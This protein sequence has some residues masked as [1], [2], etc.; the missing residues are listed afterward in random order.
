MPI[1]AAILPYLDEIS[2]ESRITGACNTIVKVP[3]SSG[4]GYKLVGQN[5]DIL[6]VRNA[7]LR[8]L[9]AQFPSTEIP[10]EVSFASGT[11]AGVIIGGG[12][13]TRSAAHALTLLG[14]S[15]IFLINRDL[16]EVRAVQ[17]SLPHLKLVLLRTPEDVER[18]LRGANAAEVLMAVGAIPSSPPTTPHERMVY[19]TVS[20]VFT[21][22][23]LKPAGYIGQPLPIPDRRIFLEMAYKPRLTPMLQVAIAHGW[24]GVDGI[25][26]MIEQG[27]AQQRMWYKTNHSLETGSDSTIFKEELERSARHLSENM[28]DV[29]E[30]GEEIDRARNVDAAVL[31]AAD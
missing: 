30:V 7:L 27:L 26:A 5:T 18:H 22:P 23:Y 9:R 14:L 13:T 16:T 10:S 12:A 20:T 24:H 8:A 28:G 11:G 2:P 25:Q 4:L 21:M 19:L 29:V 1:K 31:F 17:E 15:P 6:G 3:T